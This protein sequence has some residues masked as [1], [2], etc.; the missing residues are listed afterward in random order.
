[1]TIE[2]FLKKIEKLQDVLCPEYGQGHAT[3]LRYLYE[4]GTE[5]CPMAA[6]WNE[7]TGELVISTSIKFYLPMGAKLGLTE[8]DTIRIINASDYKKK[9]PEL[10]SRLIKAMGL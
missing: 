3:C 6:L 1:M 10:R 7:M 8:E 2:Q 5:L 9:E 4:D